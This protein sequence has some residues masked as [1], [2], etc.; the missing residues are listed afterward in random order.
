M[1]RKLPEF[2]ELS[3]KCDPQGKFRNEFLNTNIFS[4]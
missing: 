2:I 1:Y 3:K 4:S